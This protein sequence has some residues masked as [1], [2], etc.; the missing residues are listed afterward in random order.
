MEYEMKFCVGCYLPLAMDLSAKLLESSPHDE[1]MSLRMQPGKAGSF[2]IFKDGHL[3][4]SKEKSGKLPTTLDLGLIKRGIEEP[5]L[6]TG[7]KESCC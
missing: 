7:R 2:E 4:F 5:V 1:E 3:T 6:D